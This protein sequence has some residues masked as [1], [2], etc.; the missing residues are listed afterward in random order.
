M[1]DGVVDYMFMSPLNLYLETLIHN[2]MMVCVG[3]A[4]GR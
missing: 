1:K 2:V 4:F 3:G